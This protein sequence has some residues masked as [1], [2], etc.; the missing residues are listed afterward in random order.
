MRINYTILKDL[1]RKS[2][3]ILIVL[4]LVQVLY[5]SEQ[6]VIPETLEEYTKING[7]N[8]IRFSA[9]SGFYEQGF[10]LEMEA[11][12][13]LPKGAQIRYTLDGSEAGIRSTLY[14]GPVRLEVPDAPAGTDKKSV[15]DQNTDAEK[16]TAAGAGAGD[17][18][19]ENMLRTDEKGIETE[20][21]AEERAEERTEEWAEERAEEWTEAVFDSEAD[22]D[23]EEMG[24]SLSSGGRQE[25]DTGGASYLADNPAAGTRVYTVR[26][27]IICGEEETRTQYAVYGI[28]K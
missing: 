4:A 7:S 2:A 9:D 15:P 11:E 8:P 1:L 13:I 23:S 22:D 28:Q 26:A 3:V 21:R 24:E 10:S 14:E 5:I 27:K 16:D 19:T 6:P 20:E 18:Q 17:S 25:T 12:G